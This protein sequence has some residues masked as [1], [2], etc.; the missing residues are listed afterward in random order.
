MCLNFHLVYVSIDLNL[1]SN[2]LPHPLLASNYFWFKCVH[3]NP[4]QGQYRA[5]TGFS[6]WSFPHREKP[7]FIT[8]FPG[9][10]NRVFPFGKSTQGNPC[11][12]NRVPAMRT[13]FPCNE[14]RFFPARK[15]SQ[16]KPCSG[17][18]LA[19]YGIAVYI[20]VQNTIWCHLPLRNA[21]FTLTTI[22][23]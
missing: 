18:V 1:R 22:W 2:Q 15:T 4:V 12:E 14:N 3:C 11:N 19:L 16:G 13:G 17:P 9:D 10:E 8:G 21:E 20:T 23:C 5:R 7:V 6:L